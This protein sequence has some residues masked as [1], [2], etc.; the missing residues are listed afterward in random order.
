MFTSLLYMLKH[1]II[2][3]KMNLMFGHNRYGY[4]V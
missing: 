3:S 1:V 2:Y 4:N